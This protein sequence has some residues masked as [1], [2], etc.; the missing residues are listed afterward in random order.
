MKTPG[1]N[2]APWGR[3][4]TPLGYKLVSIA[5]PVG[6]LVVVEVEVDLLEIGRVAQV[7]VVGSISMM[8]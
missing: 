1:N 8:M 3:T 6:A 2:W 7:K 4:L 5:Y